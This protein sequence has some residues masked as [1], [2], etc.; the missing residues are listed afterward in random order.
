MKY[1]YICYSTLVEDWAI[2]DICSE[3]YCDDCSYTFS[4]HYQNYNPRCFYCSEQYRREK[5]T[6][7]LIRENKI[8]IFNENSV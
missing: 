7:E 2:C 1:C 6:K 3:Y 5:L 4:I 8:K